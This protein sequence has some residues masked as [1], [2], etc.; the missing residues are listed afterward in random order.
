MQKRYCAWRDGMSRCAKVKMSV[1][2]KGL[3]VS[4]LPA[5]L[6]GRFILGENT[7]LAI[8]RHGTGEPR[9]PGWG[10][11]ASAFPE[12]WVW[13]SVQRSHLA[14]R[15]RGEILELGTGWT[16]EEI[17]EITGHGWRE[18]R[19]KSTKKIPEHVALVTENDWGYLSHQSI[20]CSNSAFQMS[21]FLLQ[22]NAFSHSC[23]H[24]S[25]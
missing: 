5:W 21:L 6:V 7:G 9:E 8:M 4:G 22:W 14:Q 3:K 19:G 13:D 15:L 25:W 2:F 1:K 10:V 12:Q 17:T 24:R 11:G 18:R 20:F 16:T 23:M